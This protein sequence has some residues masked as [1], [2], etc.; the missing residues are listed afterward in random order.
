[1]HWSG[2]GDDSGHSIGTFK[3][4]G[5]RLKKLFLL[6][7]VLPLLA[8]AGAAAWMSLSVSD[9][10]AEITVGQGMSLR[11]IVVRAREKGL[12]LP[13]LPTIALL[14]WHGTSRVRPGVYAIDAGATAWNVVDVLLNG[15]PKL[16][17]FRLVEGA[18]F[19]DILAALKSS[20]AVKAD[21]SKLN[22]DEVRRAL[23]LPADAPLEGQFF[24]DTYLVAPGTAANSL[25]RT[26]YGT[27]QTRLSQAWD[28]RNPAAAVKSP[29]EALILASIIEK[30]TGRDA[31]RPLVSAVFNNRLRIGMRLQTDPTIIYGLGDSF[32]GNLRKTHLLTDGPFNTYTRVGLPPTPIALP[33]AASLMAAV[34]PADSKALYFVSRGDGTTQFSETLAEHNRAVDRFQRGK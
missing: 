34:Q 25:L 14:R 5:L 7:L 16:L 4:E 15:Q 6:A 21:A 18:T 2:A 27:M 9:Q 26:A 32:D 20:D 3:S 24:P 8:L 1:M 11:T 33:S 22:S 12:R 29:Q 13:E 19:S 10:A 17:A 31:D 23:N 28:A 30:E